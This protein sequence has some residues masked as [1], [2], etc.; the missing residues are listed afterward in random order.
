MTGLCIPPRLCVCSSLSNVFDQV[1]RESLLV[2]NDPARQFVSAVEVKAAV[3]SLMEELDDAYWTSLVRTF[4]SS[5]GKS[6][7]KK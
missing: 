5:E 2:Y 4:Y 3:Y 6:L 1:M 7:L